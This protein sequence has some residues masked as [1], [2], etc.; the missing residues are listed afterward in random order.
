MIRVMLSALAI[1]AKSFDDRDI[2]SLL[3]VGDWNRDGRLRKC[4]G[5]TETQAYMVILFL[6]GRS[7]VISINMYGCLNRSSDLTKKTESQRV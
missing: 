6:P 3:R 5:F 7:I 1:G 2:R 4:R